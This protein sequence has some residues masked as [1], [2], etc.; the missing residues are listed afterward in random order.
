MYEHAKERDGGVLEIQFQPLVGLKWLV[1]VW[2]TGGYPLLVII[3]LR[4]KASR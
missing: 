2:L 4:T 1:N 3:K